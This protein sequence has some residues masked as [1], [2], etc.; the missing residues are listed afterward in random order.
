MERSA[1]YIYTKYETFLLSSEN[2]DEGEK[3]L[4][5]IRNANELFIYFFF[6]VAE[7]LS[8]ARHKLRRL[9]NS[10]NQSK[11]VNDCLASPLQSDQGINPRDLIHY[12]STKLDKTFQRKKK[13]KRL[14]F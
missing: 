1:Y 14:S 11:K 5:L 2:T 13:S 4:Q 10:C 12:D 8:L 9:M 6:Y 3:F 7:Y